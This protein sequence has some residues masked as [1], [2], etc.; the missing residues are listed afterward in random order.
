ME[1]YCRGCQRML[2][3]GQFSFKSAEKGV[4]HSRCRACCRANSRRHY[5][6][7][8]AAYLSRNRRNNPAQR[9]RSA[10]FVLAFLREH[11]CSRCGEADPIVLEFNH[12]DAALKSAN[13]A[14][15]VLRMCSPRRLEAEMAKCEVVCAN[16]H[17]RLTSLARSWHY[18][19]RLGTRAERRA[20]RLAADARNHELVLEYLEAAACTDCGERDSL[21]LQFDHVDRKARDVA[22]LV[23]SGCRPGRLKDE[24]AKC[25]VRCAN[26]HRRRTAERAEWFRA[27]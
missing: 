15:M 8:R 18:K 3:L 23:G 11:P 26:C 27:R 13:V 10:A 22:W 4:L 5:Q 19:S 12:L 17:Q 21:V 20:F 16:C 2:P 6:A 7:N 25:E 24:L 1:R 9:R 14:D